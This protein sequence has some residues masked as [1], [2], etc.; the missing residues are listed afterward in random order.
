MELASWIYIR[1]LQLANAGCELLVWRC[2]HPTPL[3]S[4]QFESCV[5]NDR[6]HFVV[7]DLLRDI[8]RD[9]P[10][11]P[12]IHI[13]DLRCCCSSSFFFFDSRALVYPLQWKACRHRAVDMNVF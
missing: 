5:Q 4:R 9:K 8:S 7:T 11:T 1:S 12:T 10:Q 3:K 13:L 2:E 6:R